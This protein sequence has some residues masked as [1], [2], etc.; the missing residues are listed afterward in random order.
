MKMTD[1]AR[2]LAGILLKFWRFNMTNEN[3]TPTV[4]AMLRLTGANTAQ[5]MDQ[6][7]SHIEKLEMEVARLQ[8]RVAELEKE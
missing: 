7:A 8:E 4:P 1:T 2:I 5:F 3:V 6:V